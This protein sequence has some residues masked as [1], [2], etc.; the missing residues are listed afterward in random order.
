MLLFRSRNV[1]S[2]NGDGRAMNVLFYQCKQSGFN[3]LA[4]IGCLFGLVGMLHGA[5]AEYEIVDLGTLGGQSSQAAQ[6][7]NQGRVV[8]WSETASGK[9]RAFLYDQNGMAEIGTLP[10]GSE[11]AATAISREGGLVA[12]HSGINLYGRPFAEFTQAYHS[13]ND[14][15]MPLDALYCPCNFNNRYGHSEAHAV[16]ASAQIVGH[17]ETVRGS[18]VLHAFFWENGILRDIGGGAGDWSISRAFGINSTAQVVGDFA[19][20]A[21]MAG[22]AAAF[23]RTAF[24]WHNGV[25]RELGTLPG[26][27]SS[28]ALAINDDGDVVGWSGSPAGK[29]SRAFLWSADLMQDLGTLPGDSLSRA[30]GINNAGQVVGQSASSDDRDDARAFLWHGGKMVNLNGRL[31]PGSGWILLQASDINDSGMIAG[32]GLRDGQMRAFRLDPLATPV[33]P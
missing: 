15:I 23:D 31:P 14:R 8:G 30:L 26:T 16:N 32:T 7:D 9:R 24:L 22:S 3:W 21:G 13:H 18:H 12:G 19:R 6:I 5:E 11:S 29:G 10:G 2:L 4:T 28:T 20:D 25:R 17:S 1:A 33:S 27:T